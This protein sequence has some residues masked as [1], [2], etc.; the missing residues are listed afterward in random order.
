MPT[1]LQY[2]L[3]GLPNW[4]STEADVLTATGWVREIG[5]VSQGESLGRMLFSVEKKTT[6]TMKAWVRRWKISGSHRRTWSEFCSDFVQETRRTRTFLITMGEIATITQGA[7]ET[8][9][10]YIARMKCTVELLPPQ[11]GSENKPYKVSED[12]SQT[13]AFHFCKGLHE[14]H[15]FKVKNKE[16]PATLDEAF[17]LVERLSSVSRWDGVVTFEDRMLLKSRA[18]EGDAPS[19]TVLLG[20]TAVPGK[21]YD[22]FVKDFPKD[23]VDELNMDELT[24]MFSAWT[25]AARGE[26]NAASR[27]AKTIRR[28]NVTVAR[29]VFGSTEL[30]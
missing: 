17:K 2:Y 5:A 19:D 10:D 28:M 27:V 29:R 13:F 11:E 24:E 14:S 15:P 1:D 16:T 3:D 26:P 25:L 8:S 12:Y 6:G 30:A 20:N 18:A 4:P 21:Q 7:A 23:K 22:G 9:A